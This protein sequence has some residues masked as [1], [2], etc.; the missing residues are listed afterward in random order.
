MFMLLALTFV[1]TPQPSEVHLI[2]AVEH[3][4]VFAQTSAHVLGG[5]GFA[6]PSRSGWSPAHRHAQSLGQRD[7]TSEI[8]IYM[9]LS[10]SDLI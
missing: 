9:Q 1:D 4:H 10:L 8:D 7:V 5:L 3:D 2:G 6:C